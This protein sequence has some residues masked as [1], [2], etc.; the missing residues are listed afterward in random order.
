MLRVSEDI[1]PNREGHLA[2]YKQLRDSLFDLQKAADR[3]FDTIS[4]RTAQ[5]SR[6]LT[7]LSTRIGLAK[8]RVDDMAQS[9]KALTIRSPSKYPLHSKD[10]EDFKP[11]FG[12]NN[13]ESATGH[14]VMEVRVNGGLNREYGGDGTLELFQFF[15]ETNCDFLHK[16]IPAEAAPRV[17]SLHGNISAENRFEPPKFTY[18]RKNLIVD[19]E[20]GLGKVCIGRESLIVCIVYHLSLEESRIIDVESDALATCFH[21][22]TG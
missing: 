12:Y 15:S 14:P 1:N 8:A 11:L 6:K 20:Y 16:V 4:E 3:I 17:T 2:D 13:T 10:E 7:N 19:V 18:S 22:Y 21:S 9:K 5:E